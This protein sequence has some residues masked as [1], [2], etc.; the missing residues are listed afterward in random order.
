MSRLQEPT[1]PVKGFAYTSKDDE[2]TYHR[3]GNSL[4]VELKNKRILLRRSG[5]LGDTLFATSVA[6]AIKAHEHQCFVA[7]SCY[8]PY[9]DLVRHIPAIDEVVNLDSGYD[10]EYWSTFDVLIDFGGLL[11]RGDDAKFFDYYMLHLNRAGVE[12]WTVQM[13]VFDFPRDPQGF[14]AIHV[15]GSNIVKKWPTSHWESLISWLNA[16]NME[17]R[18]LGDSGDRA[19]GNCNQDWNMVGVLRLVDT[20]RVI[21]SAS[22]FI[23]TDSGLLHFA[24]SFGLPSLSFWGPFKPELTLLNYNNA[25]WLKSSIACSPCLEIRPSRCGAGGKCMRTISAEAAMTVLDNVGLGALLKKDRKGSSRKLPMAGLE[26][27]E[28][29]VHYKGLDIKYPPLDASRVS[30]VIPS[31]RTRKYLEPL[32]ESIGQNTDMDCNVVLVT[33]GDEK[34]GDDSITEVVAKGP[35]GFSTACNVGVKWSFQLSDYICLLNADVEVGKGWLQPMVDYLD[36]HK[37]VGVVGNLHYGFN[38]QIDSLGSEFS[39]NSRHFEHITKGSLDVPIERDMVTF[40]CVL[41]RRS[42]WDQLKG[43]DRQYLGGYWED[44]DFCMRVRQLGLK[45][46]CLPMS[47]V[48]HRKGGSG[49]VSRKHKSANAARF[50]AKWVDNGLVDKFARQRKRRVHEGTTTACYIVLNEVEF[51]QASID[52]IYDFCDRIIIVEGGNE[53]AVKAGWCGKD[54][55]SND[56]TIEAIKDYNDVDNKIELIQGQW[57]DKI[58]QR[59]AYANRLKHGDWMLLMDGDEIFTDEG[60]WRMSFLMHEY[61]VILP[62]FHLFWN[63]FQ[64]SCRGIWEDFPQMKAVR[65]KHGYHYRDHTFVADK[66]GQRL[67]SRTG[68]KVGDFSKEKL[69]CHYS[70]VKPITKL[71][72]KLDYY[73]FQP[74]V[75]RLV[76]NYIDRVFLAWRADPK[77]IESKYGTHPFGGGRSEIFDQEHPQ[78]IRDRMHQYTWL[79]EEEKCERLSALEVV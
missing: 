23:G 15:G 42:V 74:H 71:R 10:P 45:V 58:E 5:V 51:I 21:A 79:Y 35:L 16:R 1:T 50:R 40:A 60:L 76:E 57:K 3:P 36:N 59:T 26:A 56:G 22:Y 62:G 64:T 2:E 11:E 53:Y 78:A 70:W 32:F 19:P 44:S 30:I 73:K 72:A 48:R 31:C 46:V 69:Y 27:P 38:N 54:K 7:F 66:A 49:A 8:D 65:W 43:L 13:P 41:I 68:L 29:V 18:I 9:V 77:R 28:Y 52:S 4:T 24:G 33:N 47:H 55:R 12:D 67:S 34:W 17:Y 75:P 14:V 25:R 6:Q 63:N 20:C 61:D 39:W 37:D